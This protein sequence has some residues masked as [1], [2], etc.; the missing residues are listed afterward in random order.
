MADSTIT[1]MAE[2]DGP[3][4]LSSSNVGSEHVEA[5]AASSESQNT[6]EDGELLN[7]GGDQSESQPEADDIASVAST[8]PMDDSTELLPDAPTL[9]EQAALFREYDTGDK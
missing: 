5:A 1:P 9:V 6:L 8:A 4:T 2:D 7:E 3:V